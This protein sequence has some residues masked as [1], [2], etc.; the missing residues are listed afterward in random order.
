MPRKNEGTHAV[1]LV[2]QVPDELDAVDPWLVEKFKWSLHDYLEWLV[3]WFLT[4]ADMDEQLA[5][6]LE[7]KYDLPSTEFA[8]NFNA[9]RKL[10]GKELIEYDPLNRI[11]PTDTTGTCPRC[12]EEKSWLFD[13][14]QAGKIAFRWCLECLQRE[15]YAGRLAVI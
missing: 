10:L 2:V 5:R 8:G 7:T 3:A 11:I 4:H 6:D 1:T 15:G 12:G 14:M 9:V 13:V